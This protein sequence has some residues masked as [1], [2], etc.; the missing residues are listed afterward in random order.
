MVCRR[1]EARRW[2]CRDVRYLHVVGM[3]GEGINP[4]QL[5]PVPGSYYFLGAE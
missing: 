3:I 5:R 2:A 4:D 1:V